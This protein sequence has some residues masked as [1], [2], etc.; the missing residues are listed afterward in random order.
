M[1]PSRS[2]IGSRIS[3]ASGAGASRSPVGLVVAVLLH[4]AVIMATYVTFEHRLDIAEESPPVVP[5][6]LVTLAAKTNIMATVKPERHIAPEPIVQPQPEPLHFEAPK[7]AE[8]EPAPRADVPPKPVAKP[9]PKKPAVD[10]FEALLKKLPTA[11]SQPENAHVA[12][13]THKGFGAQDAMTMDLRDSLKN[14]IEQCWNPPAGSPHPEQLIVFV[15]LRLN[16]DGSVAGKP[17]LAAQS[18]AAAAGNPFIRAAADAA[19][20]AIFVCAPYK[21]PADRFSDWRDSTVEFDPRDV[22]GQ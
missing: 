17:Q 15:D 18:V 8:A 22:A 2:T 4:A 21:L 11:Q 19:M 3:L 14:Q 7:V 1:S 13:Q 16:P 12:A 9:Q 10:P 5:V 20:R 6:D